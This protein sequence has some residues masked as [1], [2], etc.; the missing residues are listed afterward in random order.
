[1]KSE[2]EKKREGAQRFPRNR[3]EQPLDNPFDLD[4]FQRGLSEIDESENSSSNREE[5]RGQGRLTLRVDPAPRAPPSR[6]EPP[7]LCNRLQLSKRNLEI[8]GPL[9][10]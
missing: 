5:K 9:R 2:R 6:F 1:M 7:S 3:F 10:I 4:A 8:N